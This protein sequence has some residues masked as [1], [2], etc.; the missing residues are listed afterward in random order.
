MR[1]R[2]HTLGGWR[3]SAAQIYGKLA[4]LAEQQTV[5]LWVVGSSPSFPANIENIDVD[6]CVDVVAT[7]F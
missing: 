1:L 3:N 7:A 5:N 2:M 6:V 4:Q